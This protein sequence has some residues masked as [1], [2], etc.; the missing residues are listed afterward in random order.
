MEVI[1]H[2]GASYDAPE[3]TQAAFRRAFEQGADAVECDVRLS[4]DGKI[5]VLHDENTMRVSCVDRTVADQTVADLRALDV[6]SWKGPG[7]AGERIPTLAELLAL[8]PAGKR[9]YIEVKSGL[10]GLPELTR[11][12]GA[13]GLRPDRTPVIS[14]SPAVVAAA[15]A[16]LPDVKVYWVV[17]VTSESRTWTATELIETAR[18]IGADGLDLSA[19]PAI[20]PAFVAQVAA[21]GL[22]VYVWTVNDPVEARRLGAAGVRG[23]TTDRP[24]WLQEQLAR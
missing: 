13:A 22:P 4:R 24:G 16:A 11:V 7:F 17:E 20:T 15:K 12:F 5:I 19:G 2:R 8:L 10:E 3:N 14:F 6:G 1:G 9:V 18:A 23:I 21:A